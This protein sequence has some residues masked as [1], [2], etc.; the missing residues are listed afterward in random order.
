MISRI[1]IAAQKK[2]E[3]FR[4]LPAYAENGRLVL[5]DGILG[6]VFLH[7]LEQHRAEQQ[8]G[9]QVR[10]GHERVA[11]VR[12]QPHHIKLRE[13][14]HRDG[15]AV[16]DPEGDLRLVAEE[17]DGAALAVHQPRAVVKAKKVRQI[18]TAMPPMPGSEVSKAAEVMAAPV[19]P[20]VHWPVTRIAKPVM[21]HTMIVSM[22]VSSIPMEACT[23]GEA[24]VAAA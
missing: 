20:E 3:A 22:K 9:D 14:A 16:D 7:Q 12:K 4:P 18:V 24:L 10:D 13:H 8:D 5:E 6:F 11:S 23:S 17:I 19:R 1:P 15:D 21:V 2:G